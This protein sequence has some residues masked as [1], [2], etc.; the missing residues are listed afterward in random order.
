MSAVVVCALFALA[1]ALYLHTLVDCVRT[2]PA[3]TRF[4]PKT[5][6]VLALL[7]APVLGGLAWLYLGKG[8]EVEPQRAQNG[9]GGQTFAQV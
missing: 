3:R 2:S 6:W 5:V 7:W 8:P 9:S 1:I 4:L